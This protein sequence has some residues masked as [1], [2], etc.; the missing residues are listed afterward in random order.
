MLHFYWRARGAAREEQERLGPLLAEDLPP[1]SRAEVLVRLADVDMHLGRVDEAG[2]MA[3]EALD[4]AQRGTEPHWLA[5]ASLAFHA[6]HRGGAEEAVGLGRQALAEAQALDETVRLTAI[7]HLATILVGVDRAREAR[8]LYE[9]LVREARASGLQ[10]FA[11]TGLSDL[12]RLD[13]LQQDYESGRAAYS[14]ALAELRLGGNR[15]YELETLRGLGLACLGLARRREA[16]AAFDEMLELALAATQTYSRYI[17]QALSGIAL[18]VEPAAASQ[19]ARLRG[20]V[21]RLNSDAGVA[22]NA[23]SDEDD[24]LEQRF[25]RELEEAL[26]QQAWA[27]E[28]AAG[29]MLAFEDAVA[30]A[31]SLAPASA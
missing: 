29:S 26:G 12:G 25:E 17:A 5:V 23:Y 2:A 19:A 3:R 20:A 18:A 31:R 28:K 1:Q 10:S 27:S 13:L 4:L 15:Y 24:E 16:R 14:S 11:T 7:G 22:M 30:L 8:P 9:R 6:L 21:A